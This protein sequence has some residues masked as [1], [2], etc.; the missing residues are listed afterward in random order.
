MAATSIFHGPRPRADIRAR[1]PRGS[2]AGAPQ[3][4]SPAAP[5]PAASPSLSCDA[6]LLAVLTSPL[7]PG[8]TA[9]GG[10]QRK[11]HALRA[12]FAALSVLAA[13]AL[14]ARLSA[15]RADDALALAFSRLTIERRTRLLTFLADARR[16]EALAATRR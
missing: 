6:A 1:L 9:F 4:S 14:H 5:S 15:C 8:E 11:E 10:Y 13:R 12:A 3:A 7:H 2:S 16:R